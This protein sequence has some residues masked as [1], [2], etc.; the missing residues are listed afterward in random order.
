MELTARGCRAAR[1]VHEPVPMQSP[2]SLVSETPTCSPSHAKGPCLL[3]APA[4]PTQSSEPIFSRS[5]GSG[6]TT[7]FTYIVLLTIGCSP[8]RPA[9]VMGTTWGKS[10][11]SSPGFSRAG[12]CNTGR[13]SRHSCLRG[14]GAYLRS[15]RFQA[16]ASVSGLHSF[17]ALTV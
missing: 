8:W 10:L 16:S 1:M 11:H 9:A 15:S 12:Q 5:Y 4:Q 3:P 13:C 2:G 6:L 14:R 7:S 17:T